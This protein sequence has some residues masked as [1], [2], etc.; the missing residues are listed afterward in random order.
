MKITRTVLSALAVAVVI[1]AGGVVG[2]QDVGQPTGIVKQH[3]VLKAGEYRNLTFL[4][5]VRLG[6]ASYVDPELLDEAE[7]IYRYHLADVDAD[8]WNGAA[9]LDKFERGEASLAYVNPETKHLMLG[10]DMIDEIVFL[11]I[12]KLLSS[13]MTPEEFEALNKDWALVSPEPEILGLKSSD[14]V[15]SWAPGS[16]IGTFPLSRQRK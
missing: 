6:T 4:R 1:V 8:L 16:R 13:G 14:A 5:K 10:K 3:A 2:A 9:F 12:I 15:V 11:G 7:I